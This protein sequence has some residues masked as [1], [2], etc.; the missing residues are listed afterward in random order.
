MAL[1]NFE[2]IKVT[3][4][5]TAV[6]Q[7]PDIVP[8]QSVSRNTVVEKCSVEGIRAEMTRDKWQEI[9]GTYLAHRERMQNPAV[10]DAWQQYLVVCAL[11]DKNLPV[12]LKK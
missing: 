1:D 8:F 4:I 10:R 5:I 7:W 2:D 11:A 6:Y 12:L 3:E 9:Y